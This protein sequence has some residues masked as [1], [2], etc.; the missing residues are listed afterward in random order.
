[1]RRQPEMQP[2]NGGE[3]SGKCSF[4][5]FLEFRHNPISCL[6]FLFSPSNKKQLVAPF[7]STFSPSPP[8]LSVQM[9]QALCPFLLSIL[10]LR[11]NLNASPL[12]SLSQEKSTLT[13]SPCQLTTFVVQKNCYWGEMSLL[14]QQKRSDFAEIFA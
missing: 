8:F 5:G 9:K 2:K 6:V 4:W 7:T 14:L 12:L 13:T 11:F 1:M 3:K 10:P